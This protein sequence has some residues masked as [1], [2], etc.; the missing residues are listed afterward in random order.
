MIFTVEFNKKFKC[1]VSL[2]T[3]TVE[4]IGWRFKPAESVRCTYLYFPGITLPTEQPVNRDQRVPVISTEIRL[5]NP[6][7]D[8]EMQ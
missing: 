3:T 4:Q 2:L 5:S 1:Y 7:T 8:S 6:W